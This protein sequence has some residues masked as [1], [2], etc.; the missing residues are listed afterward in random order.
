MPGLA[1][2]VNVESCPQQ[3]GVTTCAVT[4]AALPGDDKFTINAYGAQSGGGGLLSTG[5][6][7][8]TI[9]AENAPMTLAIGGPIHSIAIALPSATL[10]LGQSTALDVTAKDA[11]GATIVGTYDHPIILSAANLTLGAHSLANSAAAS[12]V[13]A[14]WN[15]GF[16]GPAATKIT[17]SADGKQGT[18]TLDPGTGIA[19]YPV[20]NK[21]ATDAVEFKMTVGADGNLYFTSVGQAVCQSNGFCAPTDMAVHKFAPT[22][23]VNS[24]IDLHAAGAGGL[25]YASDHSLWVA[26]GA[27][28]KIFRLPPND[29]SAAALQ[30]IT[31]PSPPPGAGIVNPREFTQDSKGNVWFVDASGHRV[32]KI[33]LA[34]PYTTAAITQYSL[35]R[36]PAGTPQYKANSRSIVTGSDGDLYVMDALN[37]V[38]DQVNPATGITSKQFATPQQVATGPGDIA[39]LYSISSSPGGATLYVSDPG[40]SLEINNTSFIDQFSVA[41]G[42][43][44][45][46]ALPVTFSHAISDQRLTGS[47]LYFADLGWGLGVANVST[48]KSREYPV[49][50]N[51]AQ[52]ASGGLPDFVAAMGDGTAWFTCYGSQPGVAS[53]VRDA[54]RNGFSGRAARRHDGSAIGE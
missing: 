50:L 24:E 2:Y 10:P 51:G 44:S 35:P 39:L 47:Q 26:G 9:G 54:V 53:A 22:T 52:G 41:S 1:Q 30:S 36:G 23:G 12:N 4:V 5:S 15:A 13:S 28:Q 14:S 37:G 16:A 46:I 40:D 21:A 7:A 29:F 34:G 3:A 20:A 8:A 32:M 31:L 19:Y 43:Y 27:S 18:A 17:A 38:L 11:S 25:Y 6:V 42:K 45:N 49:L 33:P 48:G